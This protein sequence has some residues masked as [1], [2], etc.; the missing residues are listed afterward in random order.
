MK[1]RALRGRREK[2]S[3]KT[4]FSCSLSL[5]E[6]V[7]ANLGKGGGE[8]RKTQRNRLLKPTE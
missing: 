6:R 7:G 8:V 5:R 1:A 2:R 4:F 3:K